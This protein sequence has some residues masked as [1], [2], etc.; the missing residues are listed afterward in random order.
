[1]YTS[2]ISTNIVVLYGL[3]G[4]S[5]GWD[6]DVIININVHTDL[7]LQIVELI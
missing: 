5:V 4:G 7:G 6:V 1:M 3:Q 2:P